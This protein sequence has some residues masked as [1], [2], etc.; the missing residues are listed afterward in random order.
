MKRL[1]CFSPVCWLIV[2]MSLLLSLAGCD[3]PAATPVFPTA[4]VQNTPTAQ[5]PATL[6]GMITYQAPPTPASMLYIISPERWY[7]MEVPSASPYSTFEMQVAPGT[8]QLV[9]FPVGSETGEFRPAAAYTSG[10][11]IASLTVTAGQVVEDLHVQNIN[12]DNCVAYTF[13]ASPDGRFPVLQETCS[14]L[15][16]EIPPATLRG[17]ISYQAPPTPASMLYFIS[18]EH[19]Y[20]LEVPAGNPMATFELQVAPGTYQLVAF[21]IGSE[22]LADRPAAAYTTGSGIGSLTVSAG[23]VVEGIRVQNINS[24]RCV[25]YAFPA[26]PD[27]RFPPIEE[28]CSKLPSETALA[29]LRGIIS[30]QAPP[31]PD[32]MLYFISGEH[33]YVLDVPGGNPVSTFELQVAPG[34]YQVVAFP[35]G[36]E[37]LAD[38]PAAAYTTGSGI[39]ALAVAAGQVMEGI[40][41]QNINSDRCVNHAF[42][43]SPDGRF[44]PLEETCSKV[45]LEDTPATIAGTITYQAPPTPA[46][47]LYIISAGRWYSL[48]VA[49][50]NPAST[51]RLQVAPG[52][53]QLVAFPAG[54]ETQSNRAAAAYSTGSGIGVLTVGPGQ[55]LEGIR[56]QNINPDRCVQYA[57][58]ASPDGR[59]PPLEADCD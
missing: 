16:T 28:N 26:S 53:Y 55:V 42:P 33:W 40:R 30:Y 21:P 11:G 8:Y 45:P 22:S 52:T 56:V 20:P 10:S 49:E 44:P 12:S 57:F 2:A 47:I 17:T 50:G 35:V 39:G 58:P 48:E 29:T 9:A 6:R 31:T 46:S 13:P 27:G 32:S 36:S 34:T 41:V 1:K 24:D 4:P 18:S 15:P 5:T 7:S 37:S 51:F 19:M 38:R 3:T 23:Q 25:N 14:K 54:S 59:F 43:A